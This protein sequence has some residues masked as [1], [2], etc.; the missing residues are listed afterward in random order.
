MEKIAELPVVQPLRGGIL[1]VLGIGEVAARRLLLRHGERHIDLVIPGESV[2]HARFGVEKVIGTVNIQLLKRRSGAVEI[3]VGAR[4]VM[5]D[6]TVL[7]VGIEVQPPRS[8]PVDLGEDV[9]IVLGRGVTIIFVT[10]EAGCIDDRHHVSPVAAVI[11]VA[12]TAQGQL[13]AT[14]SIVGRCHHAAEMVV[15]RLAANQIAFGN[16]LVRIVR[17]D[18][19]DTVLTQ[20]LSVLI[21]VVITRTVGVV[22]RDIQRPTGVEAMIDDQLIVDLGIVIRLV[23]IKRNRSVGMFDKPLRIVA[24]VGF[25]LRF[26]GAARA[27]GRARTGHTAEGDQL[28]GRTPIVVPDLQHVGLQVGEGPID[29]TVRGDMRKPGIDG[30]MAA[31]ESRTDLQ[32]LFVGVVGAIGKGRFARKFARH[33][34][35]GHIHRTAEGSRTVGRGSGTAL[36]LDR[37]DRRS[38]VG[39]IVPIDRVAL[40]IVHRHAVGCDIDARSIRTAQTERRTADAVAGIRRSHLQQRRH[41]AAEIPARNRFSADIGICHRSFAIDAGS[42]HLDLLQFVQFHGIRSHGV[43]FH[44]FVRVHRHRAPDSRSRK[45]Q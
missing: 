13:Y 17:R 20:R 11:Y 29:I 12:R 41:V 37:S 38:H 15:H 10:R 6:E 2:V 33:R 21:L 28:H 25:E 24:P 19:R 36:Y 1:P 5:P 30:P 27:D 32:R 14:T 16:R 42:G 34:G 43:R 35:G 31:H 45:R 22:A 40:G 4:N 18:R 3:V 8:L 7:Q 23:I 44:R 9:G 39:R 26:A